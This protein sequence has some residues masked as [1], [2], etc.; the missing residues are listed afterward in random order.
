MLG[1]KIKGEETVDSDSICGEGKKG[2][3]VNN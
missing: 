3:A 2:D 1:F